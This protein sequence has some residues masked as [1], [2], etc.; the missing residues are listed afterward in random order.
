MPENNHLV[1]RAI[2]LLAPS[3]HFMAASR[4]YG[5]LHR[6]RVLLAQYWW[7]IV[8]IGLLILA[9]AYLYTAASPP[10]YQSKARMW[11]AGK[12]DLNENRLFTEELVNFLGTQVELLRSPVIQGRAFARVKNQFTNATPSVFDPG[13]LSSLVHDLKELSSSFFA[14]TSRA[15]TNANPEIPFKLKVLESPKSSILELQVTGPERASTR[16]FLNCL[17]E[18]YLKFKHEAREKTSDRTVASAAG[19][20]SQLASEVKAQQDKLYAFQMSNNVVFLQE[21]GNS[22][23]NYLTLLNKQLATLRT[24]LQ[25]L[26]FIQPEQWAELARTRSGESSESAPATVSA[27]EVLESLAGPQSELFKAN[28][29]VQLLKAKRDDLSRF[30]RPLHPKIVKLNE[31]IATQEKIAQI[32]R[33]E[34]AKQLAHRRDALQLEVKNLEIASK[35]W[36]AKA[37]Q[38]SRK[39]V[40]YDRIR[41]DLQRLQASYEKLLGVIQTVDVGKTLD[42]ENVSILEPA[43]VARPLHRMLRNMFLAVAAVLLLICGLLYIATK[44]DDRFASLAELA[45]SRPE[46]ILGQIPEIVLE[47]PRGNL[48]LETLESQRFEFLE[49]F[50]N[51]RSSLL[52]MN[53]SGP[54]PKTL[55]I[56]SSVPK[57][58]KSTVSLY[59]AATL[60]IGGSRVLLVDADMRRASLHKQI[61]APASPGLAEVLNHELALDKAI[62]PTTLENLFLL[63][64]G[65]AKRNPGE[66]VLRAGWGQLLRDVSPQF[67]FVLIDTPPILATDDT[68]SLGS[69]ADGVIF[70]VRGSFTPARMVRQALEY[71]RQRRVP[72]LGLIFNR[73]ISSPY[74]YHHYERYQERYQWQPK[75]SRRAARPARPSAEVGKDLQA[76]RQRG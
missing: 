73:A 58:G 56:A 29:Q 15:T 26:D 48:G 9:P 6:Q 44:V 1:P 11:L 30:L 74:S 22:A 8:L 36:D 49:S 75:R 63:P 45:E 46:A 53:T 21:Q 41:Q 5:R 28:Q 31:E 14:D 50:R 76:A 66:L 24:E 3:D 52:F 59:L 34:A 12:L 18:E 54:R 19:Q 61:G 16:V 47:K 35:E 33:D 42:Q 57:E 39:M 10:A 64:A 27:K 67:D 62:L 70:V 51:I 68:A 69:K 17:M 13:L 23:A 72:V 60:S 25:L 7:A 40:E 38:T 20:L 4:L 37:I 65:E 71:L 43:S 55:L 32:S 2:D